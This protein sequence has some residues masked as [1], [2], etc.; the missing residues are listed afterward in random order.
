MDI[1]KLYEYIEKF[2]G[3][4]IGDAQEFAM[5]FDLRVRVVKIDGEPCIIT[6]DFRTDRI[7]VEVENDIITEVDGIY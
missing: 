3:I 2:K 6:A 1:N 7:N 4:N 5:S